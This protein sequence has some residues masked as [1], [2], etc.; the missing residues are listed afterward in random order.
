MLLALTAVFL[1]VKHHRDRLLGGTV[2]F[3]TAL[4][5]GLGISTVASVL[6][7]AGWEICLALSKSDFAHAYAR[8]L[9]K[10]AQARGASSQELQAVTAQAE[11][12]VRRY[13]NPFYR[14]GMSFLE[15]FPVGVL[16]SGVSAGLLRFRQLLPARAG[17]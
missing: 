5:V 10:A 6:Y 14:M 16:V 17:G 2:G 4:V 1:G 12:F 15:I 3:G 13:S 11:A 9:I 8:Y 7:A